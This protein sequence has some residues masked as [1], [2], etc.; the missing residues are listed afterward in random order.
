MQYVHRMREM[1]VNRAAAACPAMSVSQPCTN[2]PSGRPSPAAQTELEMPSLARNSAPEDVPTPHVTFSTPVRVSSRLP[3]TPSSSLRSTSTSSNTRINPSDLDNLGSSMGAQHT[4]CQRHQEPRTSTS[5]FPGTS[6]HH[7]TLSA[8]DGG[9]HPFLADS[10]IDASDHA[11]LVGTYATATMRAP[12]HNE[13]IGP[14][15]PASSH[16]FQPGGPSTLSQHGASSRGAPALSPPSAPFVS[17]SIT[18]FDNPLELDPNDD[19]KSLTY[20]DGEGKLLPPRQLI[21][22]TVDDLKGKSRKEKKQARNRMQAR[23]SDFDMTEN[24]ILQTATIR[25]AALCSC[26]EPLPLSHK[27]TAIAKEAWDW[28]RQYHKKRITHSKPL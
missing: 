2:A 13:N 9:D 22:R 19:P 24:C 28:A 17:T 23:A 20:G 3:T 26:M 8:I 18:A 5:R 10:T 1:Y 21:T 15:L 6:D 16:L 7:S 11:F 14:E 25:M 12:G 4:S 27:E